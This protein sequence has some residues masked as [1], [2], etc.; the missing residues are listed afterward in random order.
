MIKWV[1]SGC[2]LQ[3]NIGIVLIPCAE[4]LEP[5]HALCGNSRLREMISLQGEA[6]G[7]TSTTETSPKLER[8]GPL[9]SACI[10]RMHHGV[11]V[12]KVSHQQDKWKNDSHDQCSLDQIPVSQA[13]AG[14]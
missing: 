11:A 3:S 13:P 1:V 12:L 8:E 5:F 9:S 14:D 6:M 10:A 4:D 2:L 7:R